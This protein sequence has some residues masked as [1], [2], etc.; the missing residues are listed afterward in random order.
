[1]QRFEQLV[2]HPPH[3]ALF[4]AALLVV[5]A[6]EMQYAVDEQ[7]GQLLMQPRLPRFSLPQRSFH[8]NNDISQDVRL[9][10]R[11]RPFGHGEG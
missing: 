2:L 1:M 10:S 11:K 5:I 8:G 9:D 7:E 4:T 3:P 6:G